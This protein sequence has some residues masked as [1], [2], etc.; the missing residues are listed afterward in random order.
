MA[1]P[2]S[3]ET[4]GHEAVPLEAGS[5]DR[6]DLRTSQGD[7]EQVIGTLKTAFL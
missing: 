6:G 4:P 1:G 3:N 7:R 2:E 5:R